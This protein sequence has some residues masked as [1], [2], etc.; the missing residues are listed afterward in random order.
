MS[1]CFALVPFIDVQNGMSVCLPLVMKQLFECG[2]L[3]LG[4]LHDNVTRTFYLWH[5]ASE[6]PLPVFCKC[7]VS[8][9]TLCTEIM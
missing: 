9:I 5:V 4:T 7:G 1:L 3:A 8:N 2:K 6:V